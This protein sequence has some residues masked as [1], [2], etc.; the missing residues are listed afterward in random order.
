MTGHFCKTAASIL[1]ET[2]EHVIHFSFGRKHKDSI[3][4]QLT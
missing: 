3:N 4:T 2:A 1:L